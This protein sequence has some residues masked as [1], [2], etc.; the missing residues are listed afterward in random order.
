MV[1]D[2]GRR[3]IKLDQ[4]EC[5]GVGALKGESSFVFIKNI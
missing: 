4:A 1:W 3:N 5:I 2:D